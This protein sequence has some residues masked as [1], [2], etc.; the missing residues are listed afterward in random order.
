MDIDCPVEQ[1]SAFVDAASGDLEN[2]ARHPEVILENTHHD[3]QA[4][5]EVELDSTMG[6][7]I[8][9]VA[10]HAPG[11]NQDRQDDDERQGDDV[12]EDICA[13]A[14]KAWWE[15]DYKDL[16]KRINRTVLSEVEPGTRAV[17]TRKAAFLEFPVPVLE[18]NRTDMS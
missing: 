8:F 9:P 13:R 10:R 3:E 1:R 15:H 14:E 16:R 11:K 7:V 12:D 5:A 2:S 17:S 6:D 18:I 4:D